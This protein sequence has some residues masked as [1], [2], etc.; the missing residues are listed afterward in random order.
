MSQI[1]AVIFDWAGTVIDFGSRAPVLAMMSVF[2]Q[3]GVPLSE[4]DVRQ[5]MGMGKRD[6]VIAI[7]RCAHVAQA[8]QA[9]QGNAWS[10]EDID[11]LMAALEPAM[12]DAAATYSDLIPGALETISWLRR[13]D[14]KGR[15]RRSG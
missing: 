7:L 8:W 13:N 3:A 2:E 14:V 12:A 9:T 11:A 5:F 4:N 10:E 15:T 6:H 1:K